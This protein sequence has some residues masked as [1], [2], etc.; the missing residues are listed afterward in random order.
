METLGACLHGPINNR[1]RN[2]SAL[3]FRLQI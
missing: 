2:T 1:C 3:G